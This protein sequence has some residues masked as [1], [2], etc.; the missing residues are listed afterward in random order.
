MKAAIDLVERGLVPDW[1]T[2]RGIRML[3][4]ERLRDIGAE[5]TETAVQRLMVAMQDSPIALHP[6][7][8]NDQH[9]EVPARFF[10]LI[11]GPHLKY[12]SAYWPE[13]VHSLQ[14]AEEA[15]LKLT[16]QRAGIRNGQNI[17]DLGCGWGSLSL[18]IANRYPECK[19]TA[20]S[21]S[22]SQGQY[23]T[24]RA[25][26]LGLVN[27]RVLTADMNSFSTDERYD[28]VV[29]VEMF[30]H[31]RNIG[32]L[33]G[34]IRHWLHADGRLFVHVFAHREHA[35]PFA[36]E[37]DH[38]WMAEH[39]F[40]GGMMPS[41]DLLTRFP[42]HFDVVDH[43]RVEGTHYS[44]TL[45]AWLSKLDQRREEVMP[46]LAG[47]YG[48]EAERWL[49]RWRLFLLACSE[50]FKFRSGQEWMVGHYLLQPVG[51]QRSG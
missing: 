48:D 18:W 44:K 5:D 24:A 8:A 38:D 37:S 42:E 12:S 2:R 39:F 47:T 30:E 1:L 21:N 45:E 4:R 16:C 20:V 9:Y 14:S 49:H 11:L 26:H 40:T 13:N 35:Y 31:M 15:M 41:E 28:R 43:W 34:R 10:E 50:L 27:V 36:V 23:V 29:S 32:A 25:Q 51:D 6:R 3:L 17:L 46:V 7:A 22:A 33:L 19:I